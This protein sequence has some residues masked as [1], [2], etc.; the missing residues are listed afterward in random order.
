VNT[1]PGGYPGSGLGLCAALA[2]LALA[3]CVHE[4]PDAPV[5]DNPVEHQTIVYV[6]K[7]PSLGAILATTGSRQ[8]TIEIL[9][10][11]PVADSI[12]LERKN[13]DAGIF[14]QIGKSSASEGTYVDLVPDSLGPVLY[15]RARVQSSTGALSPY[16]LPVHFQLP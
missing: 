6:M 1:A 8:V 5:W 4:Y 14:V 13:G 9:Q 12:L 7:A 15:Y 3:S 2:A 10:I 16:S 11:D